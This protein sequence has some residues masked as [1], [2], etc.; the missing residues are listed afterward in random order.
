MISSSECAMV[1]EDDATIMDVVGNLVLSLPRGAHIFDKP[2]TLVTC[3][4]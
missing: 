2:G 1:T 3:I 4:K